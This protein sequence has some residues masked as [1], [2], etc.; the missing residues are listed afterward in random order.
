MPLTPLGL[1]FSEALIHNLNGDCTKF[2]KPRRDCEILVGHAAIPGETVRTVACLLR[3]LDLLAVAKRNGFVTIPALKA[4]RVD[5]IFRRCRTTAS[6]TL[7]FV[8][9]E[10]ES[11]RLA[12]VMQLSSP[13]EPRGT[14]VEHR[15]P[16]GKRR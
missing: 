12:T 13:A 10:R 6:V 4:L 5:E 1:A 11:D 16:L 7:G 15:H 2:W 14:D 8:G 3:R 9:S